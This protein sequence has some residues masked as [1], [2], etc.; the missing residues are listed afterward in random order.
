M[1]STNPDDREPWKVAT[2][3]AVFF[4]LGLY[5]LWK[6]PTLGKNK[7]WWRCAIAYVLFGLLLSSMQDRDTGT[8]AGPR[9]AVDSASPS[10]SAAS[11]TQDYNEGYAYAKAVM[12]SARIAPA[13]QKEGIMNAITDPDA[14]RGK[15]RGFCRGVSD[16]IND[17]IKETAAELQR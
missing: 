2:A 6:H 5:W 8:K 13:S 4:P 16:A 17:V 3:I 7:I 14:L 9:Q 12:L 15:P 10:T 11:D 1:V